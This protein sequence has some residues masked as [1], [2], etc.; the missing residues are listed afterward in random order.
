MYEGHGLALEHMTRKKKRTWYSLVRK[1]HTRYTFGLQNSK[2]LNQGVQLSGMYVNIL[3][4]LPMQ[5]LLLV[6]NEPQC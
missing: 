2:G 4:V 5:Q 3:K 6:W 1:I